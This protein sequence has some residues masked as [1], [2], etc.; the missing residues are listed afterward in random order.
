MNEKKIITNAQENYLKAIYAIVKEKGA[1]RVK[2]IAQYLN[3][4][5]SSVSEALKIIAAKDLINYE[6][7][8][9]ISLTEEGKRLAE[10]VIHRHDTLKDFFENVLTVTP[11]LSEEAASKAKHAIP[12]DVMEKFLMF[13]GFMKTCSCK[14]PKWVKSFKHYSQNKKLSEKCQNCI[15]T[16]KNTPHHNNNC[17]GMHS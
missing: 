10:E 7:Y 4:G 15:Q 6:P 16:N 5:A 8:G 2:Y 9:L 17:C 11:E 3:I 1:A 14:E 12:D 13:L